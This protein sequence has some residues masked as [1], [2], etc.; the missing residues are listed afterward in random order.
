MNPRGT[1]YWI[2]T[3]SDGPESGIVLACPPGIN[4]YDAGYQRNWSDLMA[5]PLLGKICVQR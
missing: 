4:L 2:P 5:R 1:L 3:T